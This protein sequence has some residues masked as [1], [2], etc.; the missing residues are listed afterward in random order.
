MLRIV[1]GFQAVAQHLLLLRAE[2][3]QRG[4]LRHRHLGH[5]LRLVDQGLQHLRHRR[6]LDIA[7]LLVE[8]AALAVE[9]DGGRPAPILV[10]L[11]QGGVAV[12]VDLHRDEMIV[13]QLDH[14]RILVGGL[15]HHVAPVAPHRLHIE[16]HQLVLARSG[17]E[18]LLRPGLPGDAVRA[19]G[20]AGE[21]EDDE[22]QDSEGRHVTLPCC[23]ITYGRARGADAPDAWQS[24]R[25]SIGSCPL[26][27]R[28]QGNCHDTALVAPLC[29]CSGSGDGWSA[30]ARP[31]PGGAGAPAEL[32]RHPGAGQGP[33]RAFQRLGRRPAHQ[34][35]HRLG[36]RERSKSA[37]ASRCGT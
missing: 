15:V 24:V 20:R 21:E 29:D 28:L 8:L 36:G 9:H 3:R 12:L 2:Q 4:R 33:D 5:R 37:P 6:R 1:R 27:D 35:L 30:G 23:Q 16:Q 32:G 34:R 22:G 19:R 10:A 25:C 31:L 26:Q 7:A 14:R 17:G 18:H 11:G 13:D